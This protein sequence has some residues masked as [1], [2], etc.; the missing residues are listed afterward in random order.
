MSK[1]GRPSILLF[2]LLEE[3]DSLDIRGELILKPMNPF[4]FLTKITEIETIIV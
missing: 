3:G 1:N 4:D 2:V